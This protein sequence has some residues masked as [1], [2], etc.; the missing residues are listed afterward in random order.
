MPQ[1]AATIKHI[2]DGAKSFTI[3]AAVN[4]IE[5]WEKTLKEMDAPGAKALVT[6]LEHLKKLL[7]ADPIDGSAVKTLVGKLGKATVTFAGKADSKNADKVKQLGEALT[8]AA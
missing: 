3:S 5:G 4:N 7:H 8:A 6:D 1:F 2:A